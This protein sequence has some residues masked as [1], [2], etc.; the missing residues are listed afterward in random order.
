VIGT[1]PVRFQR[2]Q[3]GA[4]PFGVLTRGV[5]P[6]SPLAA[7]RE[8]GASPP[9]PHLFEKLTQL[10]N[11]LRSATRLALLLDLDG[12]LVPLKSRPVQVFLDSPTRQVLAELARH[13]KVSL[14]IISGRRLADLQRIVGLKAIKCL[15]LHGWEGQTH[16]DLPPSTTRLTRRA[17]K[18]F[19]SALAGLPGL[20]I[21]QK[22]PI[23]V[24]HYR[25]APAGIVRRGRKI[26]RELMKRFQGELRLMPG[27]KIWEIL[28]KEFPKKGDA[29]AAIAAQQP[30]GCAVIYL[31]DDVTDESAFS[32]LPD[33]ITVRVGRPARTAARFR[34]R[35]PSEV[36]QFLRMIEERPRT[37][38]QHLTE[39][40][41]IE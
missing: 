17:R 20:W 27:K 11:R 14:S 38:K 22:G 31:G 36:L 2:A 1:L 21:E 24:V 13:P 39:S 9:V 25:G 37:A 30:A 40:R 26:V 34:L 41:L 19:E 4:E 7:R 23:F 29:A 33:A 16:R 5:K 28:P 6:K 12:T 8:G 18:I 3:L 32:A 10:T 15:G 35:N